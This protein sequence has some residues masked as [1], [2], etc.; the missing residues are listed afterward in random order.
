MNRRLTSETLVGRVL[1]LSVVVALLSASAAAGS[2]ARAVGSA[3]DC[4]IVEWSGA[5]AAETPN[6]SDPENWVG[7][8]RPGGC[9]VVRFG[10]TAFD[11]V[12]DAD[13]D[14]EI[15]GLILDRGFSGTVRLRRTLRIDGE[16]VVAG[17]TLEQGRSGIAAGNV[18]LAGGE[19]DGGKASLQVGGAVTVS[20]GELTTPAGLMR[21]ERLEIR[22]PGVVRMGRGGKLEMTAAR[23]PLVGDGLLDTASNRPNSV[24]YT[25]GA[26]D[27]LTAAAPMIA[28]LGFGAPS[29]SLPLY[30]SE[31]RLRTALVDAA[32]GFAYFGTYTTPAFVVKVRLSDLTRVGALALNP[33]EGWIVSGSLD[34][35]NGFAYFGTNGSPGV[36]VKVRLADFQRVAAVTLAPGE[37]GLSSS[38]IDPANDALYFGTN[39][40][41]ARVVKLQLSDFTRVASVIFNEGEDAARCAVLD[42]ALGY[43]YFGTGPS[44]GPGYVVRVRLS[45]FQRVDALALGTL[46]PGSAVVDPVRHLAYFGTWD[47]P[48]R[49]VKVDLAGFVLS[50]TLTLNSG[51]YWLS[52]GV[53][54]PGGDFALFGT[55]TVPGKV[56]KVRLGDMIRIGSID[57]GAGEGYL[58]AAAMD[59]GG[60]SVYFGG[61]YEPGIIV[62]LRI[63]DL[64]I[65]ASLR[66]RT[67]ENLPSSAVVDA[68]SGFAPFDPMGGAASLGRAEDKF[69]GLLEGAA[70]QAGV[71][72]LLLRSLVQAESDFDPNEVSTAGAIG[73]TQLMPQTAKQLGVTDPYDPG[74][75]LLGGARYLA[76]ML[77]E[78]GGDERLALAAYNAG[79]GAVKRHGGIPPYRETQNYVRKVMAQVEALRARR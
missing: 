47:S 1:L 19:L 63:A 27:D 61:G 49:V 38:L 21:V 51:E 8:A 77:K 37:S 22:A 25:G 44:Y 20:G 14:G 4:R 40:L 60:A 73:L 39:T 43:A 5:A 76:S 24:E 78:F 74:Q 2:E 69:K 33:G 41:P 66:L 31:G 34:P 79:P 23:E 48:G 50:S 6:W 75:N 18:L 55:N 57:P 16:L 56:V 11:S 35:S 67:G 7:G 58:F 64:A 72:P 26:P 68:E 54:D 53:I 9:D 45:D 36:V 52:S 3:R 28:A 15:A 59:P 62:K 32:N 70:Q 10:D 71:D 29:A 46:G 65:Q 13:F 30:P 42:P 12:V 17:G